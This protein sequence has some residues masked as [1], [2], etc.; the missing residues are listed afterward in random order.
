MGNTESTSPTKNIEVDQAK[1]QK[2]LEY[3]QSQ[4]LFKKI[5]KEQKRSNKNIQ[6]TDNINEIFT[7]QHR[8]NTKIPQNTHIPRMPTIQE[9]EPIKIE[10]NYKSRDPSF[11]KSRESS[12]TKS[13]ES[14]FTKSRDG[15]KPVDEFNIDRKRLDPFKLLKKS[16]K[17]TVDELKQHYKKLVL[18]HHPDRGGSRNNFNI[19]LEALDEIN[20]LIEYMKSDRSHMDL[21]NNYTKNNESMDKTQNIKLGDMAKNFK[22]DKFNDVFNNSKLEDDGNR[23]YGHMM[24]ESIKN[25]DD[26]DIENNMGKY[27]KDTFNKKFNSIKNEINTNDIVKYRVP[28]PVTSNT[29]CYTELGDKPDDLSHR[30]Q[31]TIYTDYKKAYEDNY[32]IDPSKI[33]IRNYK[34]INELEKDREQLQLSDEQIMAIEMDKEKEERN[35]WMRTQRLQERDN[36]LYEH[37]KKQNKLFLNSQ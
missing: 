13:R 6:N 31:N 10:R 26:I 21:K 22:I 7:S 32:L 28:E 30:V 15:E 34:D 9:E 23:G 11:T 1:Y 17:L 35:E 4:E 18:I 8:Y 33:N 19:L 14:S 24:D 5:N 3:Q 27:S 29:L 36:Y 2:F 20:K 37:H 25:R 16:P 12:F